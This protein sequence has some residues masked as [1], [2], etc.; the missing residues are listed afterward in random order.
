MIIKGEKSMVK[1][2]RSDNSFYSQST[3][4]GVGLL[5]R[6]ASETANLKTSAKEENLDLAREKMRR[7]LDMLLNYD[8][9]SASA[10]I[11]P[12]QEAQVEEVKAEASLQDEDI[13]PTGTTMQFG[14]VDID[15]MRAEMRTEESDKKKYH[16]TNKGKIAITIYSLIVMVIMALI[17]VNSGM[18]SSYDNAIST[19]KAELDDKRVEYSQLQQ[20]NQ[21]VSSDGYIIDNAGEGWEIR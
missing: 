20:E 21:H 1:A 10:V 13:R 17:V 12:E 18:I 8:K 11:A 14:D 3:T 16:I 9:V 7:N 6:P 2:Q 15:Q 5:E 19:A 4:G